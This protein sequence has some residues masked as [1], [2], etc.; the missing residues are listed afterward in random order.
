M[1]NLQTFDEFLN[2]NLNERRVSFKGKTKYYD[3][4]REYAK[5]L[6][7]YKSLISQLKGKTPIQISEIIEKWVLENENK[8]ADN[9]CGI[10]EVYINCEHSSEIVGQILS[11]AKIT[12][13]LQV[14]NINGQSHAWG[15][16]DNVIIDPTK[17]QFPNISVDD[18]E[19]DIYWE[20]TFTF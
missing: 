16:I 15:K 7:D 2:E 4:P 3:K 10:D 12:H 18:Y 8:I 5:T 14:G 1:K 13:T 9:I 6:N 19:Q 11:D 20:K 17:D